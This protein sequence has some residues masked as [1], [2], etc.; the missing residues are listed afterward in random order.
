MGSNIAGRDI[1]TASDRWELG[2]L[3]RK[4]GRGGDHEKKMLSS[5]SEP[6]KGQNQVDL[7][8]GHKQSSNGGVL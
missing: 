8:Y 6:G 1:G 5:F 4:I 7:G 2:L 3:A